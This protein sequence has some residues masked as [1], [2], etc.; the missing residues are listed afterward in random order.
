MHHFIFP[1][2][3]VHMAC[4]PCNPTAW[5]HL[6]LSHM[7]MCTACCREPS[8]LPL[9]L[10]FYMLSAMIK[11]R[12]QEEGHRGALQCLLDLLTEHPHATCTLPPLT[13]HPFAPRSFHALSQPLKR[14]LNIL[15][16][17][18]YSSLQGTESSHFEDCLRTIVALH[19]TSALHLITPS[20][21]PLHTS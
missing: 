21:C 14:K 6:P 19:R 17:T 9:L 1:L 10:Q 8:A 13:L 18:L 12:G 11:V 20:T 2:S 5:A 15:H 16:P 4:A 3:F 7:G